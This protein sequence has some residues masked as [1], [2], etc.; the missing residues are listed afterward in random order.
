MLLSCPIDLSHIIVP[1]GPDTFPPNF[2]SM[3]QA[4]DSLQY[5]NAFMSHLHVSWVHHASSS[6]VIA[7]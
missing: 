5:S 2:R 3:Q 7:I 1:G 6:V 4:L